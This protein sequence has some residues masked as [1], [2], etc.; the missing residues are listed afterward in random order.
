MKSLRIQVA[1][2]TN[3]G[4]TSAAVLIEQTLKDAGFHVKP[5]NNKD[6]DSYAKKD[7]LGDGT[8][9]RDQLRQAF[10]DVEVSI[11][12]VQMACCGPAPI[13][14]TIF[15]AS[16][17]TWKSFF[18]TK[19][20]PSVKCFLLR[21]AMGPA[22]ILDGLITILSFSFLS[23]GFSLKVARKLAKTRMEIRDGL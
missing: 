7:W 4:K 9:R 21:W 17:K 3:T 10:S 11:E 6:G 14:T 23:F 22:A 18:V 19:S 2:L 16:K 8:M 5:F 15:P 12:E 13:A 1:G 20:E